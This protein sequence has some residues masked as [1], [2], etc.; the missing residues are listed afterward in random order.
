MAQPPEKTSANANSMWGGHYS[1]GPAETFARINASID[2]DKNLYKQDIAASQ[3]H[4]RM[5]AAE[6]IIEQADADAIIKG[7]TQILGEIEAGKMEFK[8]ALEDIHMHVESRLKEI[9]G[10]AAG[11]LHTARSRNDQVVTDFRLWVRDAIDAIDGEL[12]AF[13][14]VLVKRADEHAAT[15]LPGFTHLQAAQPVTLGHHLMAY[16]EMITRD[17]GRFADAR[18]RLNESPLGAA[19]LAGTSFP[20]NREMTAK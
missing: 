4:C 16:V 8:L 17:R 3:A 7:L 18:T 9:I 13:Q 15:I 11:R 6:G 1:R 19:A 14:A 5:L 20:I 12:A 10:D 2:V